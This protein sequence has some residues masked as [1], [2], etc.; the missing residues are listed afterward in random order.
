MVLTLMVIE[1]VMQA[2]LTN[3]TA[4][5]AINRIAHSHVIGAHALGHRAGRAADTKEPPRHFLAGAN[6]SK[7]A[8]LVTV[9]VDRLCF[10]RGAEARLLHRLFLRHY[11][12]QKTLD[13]RG[14]FPVPRPDPDPARSSFG[15]L[16]ETAI[17]AVLQTACRNP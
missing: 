6:F 2:F 5:L 7:C 16:Q 12:V 8:V 10:L 11:P 15:T 3:I 17:R 1:H 13:L 14:L 9:E 4:R